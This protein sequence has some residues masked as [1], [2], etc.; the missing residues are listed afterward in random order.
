MKT[1]ALSFLQIY[2]VSQTNALLHLIKR[3]PILSNIVPD[4][5]YRMYRTKRFFAWTG[6]L[7]DLMKNIL[8]A[9]AL[10]YVFLCMIPRIFIAK[11]SYQP[12]VF[13]C[14]FFLIY[15][16]CSI[17]GGS[18]AF[19]SSPEDMMFIHHFMVNPSLYYPYKIGKDLVLRGAVTF[20]VL[21]LISGSIGTAFSLM[22]FRVSV[23]LASSV[24]YLAF[25][26][27]KNRIPHIRIREWS[28]IGIIAVSFFL[29]YLGVFGKASFSSRFFVILFVLCLLISVPLVLYILHYTK[30]PEMAIKYADK[31]F[32]RVSVSSGQNINEGDTGLKS[33]LPSE[34]KAYFISNQSLPLEQYLDKAFHVRYRKI[35]LEPIF[36]NFLVYTVLFLILGLF[37]RMGWLSVNSGNILTYSPFLVSILLSSSCASRYTQLYFRNIDYYILSMRLNTKTYI[38]SCMRRRYGKTL[39]LDLIVLLGIVLDTVLLIMISGISFEI[40]YVLYAFAVCL[41]IL[42]IND[43]YSWLIYYLLQPYSVDLTVGSPL[44]RVLG[45][46][47]AILALLF[48]FI[49]TNLFDSLPVI[50]LITAAFVLAY[51]ILGSFSHKTFRLRY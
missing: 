44:Y 47:E 48:V 10:I 29:C 34:L 7:F 23:L 1:S 51:A 36:N 37:I 43:T 41:P 33:C 39:C 12:G 21:L 27:R 2:T 17:T 6:L 35:L 5:V 22:F 50:L 13:Y 46:L 14:L 19:R 26:K 45:Y 31:G 30:Y 42:V 8:S 38:Q 18:P 32:I 9:N 11:D 49:R 25:F 15:G 24:F 16:L 20:P 28:S 4:S 3:L 40:R